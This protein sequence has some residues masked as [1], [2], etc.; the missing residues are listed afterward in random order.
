MAGTVKAVWDL[1]V[2]GDRNTL[3]EVV[4][5]VATNANATVEEEAMHP[6]AAGCSMTSEHMS[7]KM[8]EHVSEQRHDVRRAGHITL[9]RVHAY[10]MLFSNSF[11]GYMTVMRSCSV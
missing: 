8:N 5:T 4:M 6:T 2:C 10:S 11:P 1:Q 9:I 7:G 3:T